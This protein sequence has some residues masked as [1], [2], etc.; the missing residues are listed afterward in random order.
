MT[1]FA[2]VSPPEEWI[3]SETPALESLYGCKFPL[4]FLSVDKWRKLHRYKKIWNFSSSVQ[5]D[6]SRV[7]Y[8]FEH[9]KRADYISASN[10]LFYCLLDERSRPFLTRKVDVINK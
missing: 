7:S 1:M 10:H 3:R 6:S 8:R 4:S 9:E 2:S 5:L